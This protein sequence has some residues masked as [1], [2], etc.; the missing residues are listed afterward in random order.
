[1]F[2]H[3]TRKF[4]NLERLWADGKEIS[5]PELLGDKVQNVEAKAAAQQ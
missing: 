3:E 4:Y 2:H 1:V 5:L